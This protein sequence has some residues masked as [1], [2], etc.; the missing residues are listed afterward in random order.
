LQ[1][2]DLFAEKMSVEGAKEDQSG[3]ERLA[4]LWK[5][6]DTTERQAVVEKIGLVAESIASVIPVVTGS[7]ARKRRDVSKSPAAAPPPPAEKPDKKS[8]KKKDKKDSKKEK[9]RKK[10]KKKK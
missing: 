5:G 6:L 2:L 8:E 7:R 9:K 3:V 4:G 1:A 10:E